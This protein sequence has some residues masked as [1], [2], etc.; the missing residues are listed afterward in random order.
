MRKGSKRFQDKVRAN[1]FGTPL[2]LWTVNFVRLLDIPYYVFHDYDNLFIPEFAIEKKRCE[3]YA[4]ENHKTCE[5]IKTSN[6]DADIYV[7]FQVT[8]P[9][10][11]YFQ[12]L[13]AIEDFYNN[14]DNFECGFNAKK[15]EGYFI[16][17]EGYEVNHFQS[18]RTDNGCKAESIY[19]ETGSFYIFNRSQLDKKHILDGCKRRI[20]EDPFN[21]DINYKEDLERVEWILG[22]K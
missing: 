1:F 14:S 2:Y 16:D 7:L 13:N 21:I 8:S 19:K 17:S 22:Q 10:R 9:L 18:N 6:I 5:E 11:S 12:I 3:Y 15:Y 20:Y 4:S